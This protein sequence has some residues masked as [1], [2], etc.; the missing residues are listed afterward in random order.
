MCDPYILL[1]MLKYFKMK[2]KGIFSTSTQILESVYVPAIFFPRKK[3][4]FCREIRLHN[5][6]NVL[7]FQTLVASQ[8]D[9]N[10]STNRVKFLIR[11][12]R[13]LKAINLS[14]VYFHS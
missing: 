12:D 6:V 10:R 14:S 2:K 3:D 13:P 1:D 4:T 8:K 9:L 5:M 7:K 11:S